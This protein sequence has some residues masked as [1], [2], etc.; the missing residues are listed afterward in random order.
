MNLNLF[1]IQLYS[2][3]IIEAINFYFVPALMAIA[4][5]TFLW[6]VYKYFILGAA[7]DTERETGRQFVLWG[8]IGF[9]VIL[10]FWGLVSIVGV[11]FF[12]FVPFG[13]V[14]RYPTL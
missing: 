3:R 7:N 9:V 13:G 5:I 6:G 2:T 10:S 14:P 12:G 1:P 11:T 4:L 8:I